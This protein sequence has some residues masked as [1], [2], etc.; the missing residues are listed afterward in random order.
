M[1]VNIIVAHEDYAEDNYEWQENEWGTLNDNWDELTHKIVKDAALNARRNIEIYICFR[2]DQLFNVFD[3]DFIKKILETATRRVWGAKIHIIVDRTVESNIADSRYWSNLEKFVDI[4]LE[5]RVT[6]IFEVG[7]E[8]GIFLRDPG[9][10]EPR[11][12][13]DAISATKESRSV[14]IDKLSRSGWDCVVPRGK[15]LPKAGKNTYFSADIEARHDSKLILH[16]AGTERDAELFVRQSLPNHEHRQIF[17]AN[18]NGCLKAEKIRDLQKG[19]IRFLDFRGYFDLYYF[20][21]KHNQRRRILDKSDILKQVKLAD[22]PLFEP[23]EIPAQ[24]RFLLVNA[25]HVQEGLCSEAA[26][27]A[28]SINKILAMD[29]EVEINPGIDFKYLPES[30][31]NVFFT[32]FMF[33][34]HGKGEKGLKDI[35]EK[36]YS[37]E[38]LL[39]CF[40]SYRS[41]LVLAYF[42][43]CYSAAVAEMFAINRV[44]VSIG[45]DSLVTSFATKIVAEEV[46]QAIVKTKEKS[47]IVDEIL[48]AF[49]T[50]ADKLIARNLKSVKP[51][52]YY[53]DR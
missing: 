44:G 29:A 1:P 30:V 35:S 37:P 33:Q 26:E 28:G 50:A 20:L 21:R 39:N 51:V 18:I 8:D 12:I 2:G 31:E 41:G 47:K 6:D 45:F 10:I 22:K 9:E 19:E 34:G 23:F 7:S 25:F 11:L 24:P 53:T 16:C 49:E 3:F 43:S 5:N 48:Q 15:I 38:Q 17:I 36:F 40:K 27:E 42:A 46:L 52:A 14:S 4:A 13:L 32:A